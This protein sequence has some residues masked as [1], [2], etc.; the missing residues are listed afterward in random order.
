MR[1]LLLILFLPAMVWAQATDTVGKADLLPPDS[2]G[3]T[4]VSRA[5]A[6]LFE[7]HT[8]QA[9]DT[10]IEVGYWGRTVLNDTC[11]LI[12]GVYTV[13]AGV[14]G[15]NLDTAMQELNA[16]GEISKWW[17]A[18]GLA[19]GLDPGSTYCATVARD[20][21][22]NMT[23]MLFSPA[24]SDTNSSRTPSLD[25]LHTDPWDNNNYAT[26][27]IAAYMVVDTSG[28]I[29]IPSETID[30]FPSTI[31]ANTRVGP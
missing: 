19:W 17:T 11:N 22:L 12:L 26:H 24:T 21:N 3:A 20:S 13:N 5:Y 29:P 23:I 2:I 18:T 10:V 25:P 9:G 31:G 30:I 1:T 4:A 7:T 8:A 16:N 14:V 27:Y 28:R 6:Q 15:N